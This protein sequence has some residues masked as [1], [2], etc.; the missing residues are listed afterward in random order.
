MR[1]DG[2]LCSTRT[3]PATQPSRTF[4][5]FAQGAHGRESTDPSITTI[6]VQPEYARI[7]RV[8]SGQSPSFHLVRQESSA[9]A[10]SSRFLL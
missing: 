5:V 3:T 1:R 9:V 6:A 8:A 4:M 7:S 10:S 2:L